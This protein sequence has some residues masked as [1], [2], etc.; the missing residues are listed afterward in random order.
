MRHLC[1]LKSG[2]KVIAETSESI[3]APSPSK[4]VQYVDA[5]HT[6]WDDISLSK[7]RFPM[8]LRIKTRRT[9]Q[10]LDVIARKQNKVCSCVSYIQIEQLLLYNFCVIYS[11]ALLCA[12][13]S[14]Q[15]PHSRQLSKRKPC[16]SWKLLLGNLMSVGR[17]EAVK[18]CL[19]TLALIGELD[20]IIRDF[21]ASFQDGYLIQPNG[22]PII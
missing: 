6:D 8:G 15:W 16:A 20:S 12:C 10:L 11:A 7:R 14:F 19:G 4:K 18:D 5:N 17:L 9:C 21:S 2:C 3:D 1:A 13:Y 22:K